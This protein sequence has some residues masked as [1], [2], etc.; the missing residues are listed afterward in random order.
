M[1]EVPRWMTSL[2]AFL[3]SPTIDAWSCPLDLLINTR[4][5]GKGDYL[6]IQISLLADESEVVRGVWENPIKISGFSAVAKI[7]KNDMLG[8]FW[9]TL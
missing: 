8:L 2:D 7:A 1:E 9:D 5:A 6:L 3:F 4:G